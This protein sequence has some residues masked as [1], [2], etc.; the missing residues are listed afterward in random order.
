[1]QEESIDKHIFNA[2]A[3]INFEFLVNTPLNQSGTAKEV[4]KDELNNGVHSIAEDMVRNMDWIYW[5]IA[6]YRYQF[7]YKQEEL[8]EMV[9]VV[10]VPEKY[11]ILSS[12][13]LEEQLTSAKNNKANPAIINA[14]EI[15]YA[16]KAFNA[17]PEVRDTVEL[18]L[19]LD[20]LSNISEDDKNSRLQNQGILKE[21]YVISSNI[22]EFVQRAIEENEGF[23]DMDLQE[24]KE[25]IK[26]YAQELMTE[27]DK[28]KIELADDDLPEDSQ[29]DRQSPEEVQQVDS[30][31]ATV[32]I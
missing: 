5:I 30:G 1:M 32:N 3:S 9:P 2:L 8:I 18:V 11:D 15:E 29:S 23:P 27:Q 19:S 24:Q 26:K 22:N 28:M 13:H 6:K 4:D 21:T 25:V 17:D 10:S 31:G 20:P 12:K 16:G 7:Q 14:L